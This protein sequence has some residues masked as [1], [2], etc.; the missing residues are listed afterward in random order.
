MT[1]QKNTDAIDFPSC[2]RRAATK[3]EP[4]SERE[5]GREKASE[6][7]DLWSAGTAAALRWASCLDVSRRFQR[8]SAADLRSAAPAGK[9][10]SALRSRL[11][12]LTRRWC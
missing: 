1:E 2:R 9:V 4:A 8:G 10:V 5:R 12:A 7:E 11:A 6:R 3:A